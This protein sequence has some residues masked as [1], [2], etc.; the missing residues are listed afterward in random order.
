MDEKNNNIPDRT[1]HSL[2]DL[3]K[4][5][6]ESLENEPLYLDLS[7]KEKSEVL[8]QIKVLIDREEIYSLDKVEISSFNDIAIQLA[9]KSLASFNEDFYNTFN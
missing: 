5:I 8:F 9:T 1:V 4:Y 6:Y 2:L 7:D 3:E